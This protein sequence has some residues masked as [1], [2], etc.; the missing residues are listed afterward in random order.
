MLSQKRKKTTSL[1]I[2][3][4]IA[5]LYFI[6]C[7]AFYPLSY[8]GIQVRFAEALTIL[9]LFFGEAVWGVTIGCLISNFFSQGVLFL[10]VVFGTLA[11]LISAI[12]TFIISKKIKNQKARYFIGAFPPVIINAVVVPFTFL[13]LFELKELYFISMIQIFIGQAISIY[14]IGSFIY[15][16]LKKILDKTVSSYCF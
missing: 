6:I 5:G 16:P 3:G 1:S 4:I 7:I 11:T 8:G 2:C 14:I 15:F 10:D 12:L 13:A 9:P